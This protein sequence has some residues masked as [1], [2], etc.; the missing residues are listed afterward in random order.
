MDWIKTGNPLSKIVRK[1]VPYE[2]W[3]HCPGV[4]NPADLPSRGLSFDELVGN[5]LWFNG[6]S[7][8]TNP[9]IMEDNIAQMSDECA[10]ELKAKEREVLGLLAVEKFGLSQIINVENYSGVNRLYRIT[11][12]ILKF[13][14]KLKR[15]SPEDSALKCQSEIL[16]IKECQKSL[17]T[18]VKFKVWKTQFGLFLD[19]SQVWRCGGRLVEADL[20]YSTR[21][22]ILL[23]RK[24]RL[25]SL[26]V[27]WAHARV[28]H[29]GVKE[30]LTKIRS[31]YWIIKGRQLIKYLISRCLC[32]RKYEGR[33]Y[34][35]PPPPPLPPFR[36][37]EEPSFSFTGI[38]FAGPLHIRTSSHIVSSDKVW[39]CLFTC[40]VVRAIHLEIVVDLTAQSFLR[41]LK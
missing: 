33:P 40:C 8:L 30:T 41:C 5:T 27:N 1:L 10:V 31:K 37:Q 18:D 2:Q 21:H 32:C 26:I 11:A 3:R 19:S 12:Y 22:P 29:D 13:I 6:P 16:W 25:T 7:W 23:P 14:Q 34:R 24:H 39:V 28:M 20:P 38:D 35:A 17:V 9:T 15:L 4:S 36:V